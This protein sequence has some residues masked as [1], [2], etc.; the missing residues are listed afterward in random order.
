MFS[1][2]SAFSKFSLSKKESFVL[3]NSAWTAKVA[4]VAKAL[5]MKEVR[6]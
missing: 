2:F 5:K 3:L 6:R 1:E 4:K